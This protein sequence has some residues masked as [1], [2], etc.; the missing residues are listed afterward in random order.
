[1]VVAIDLSLIRSGSGATRVTQES[2]GDVDECRDSIINLL[3]GGSIRKWI[4]EVAPS[5]IV[6]AA[7]YTAVDKAESEPDL[8]RT[9]NAEAPAV[10][11]REAAASGAWLLHYSTDYVFDGSGDAPRDEDAPTGP[12]ARSNCKGTALA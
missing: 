12:P 6:N 8:A 2:T 7:A 11:A 4:R 3:E 1:M 5:V 9:I 10:L